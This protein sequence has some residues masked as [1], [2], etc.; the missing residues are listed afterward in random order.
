MI[1]APASDQTIHSSQR[2]TAMKSPRTIIA[3]VLLCWAIAMP[4][5]IGAAQQG[6]LKDQLVGTWTLASWERTMPDG[7]KAQSY[8]TSPKGVVMFDPNGRM[9]AM[10]ARSDLPR[11]SSNNP[12]VATPEEAKAVMTG[13]IAYFGMYTVDDANKTISLRL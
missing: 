7:T 13:L 3:V 2:R 1:T 12:T 8:G 6:S 9:F 4:A 11:I 10:F 5:T